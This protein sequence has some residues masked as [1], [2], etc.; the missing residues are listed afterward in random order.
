M[1]PWRNFT[2]GKWQD[3]IDVRDFIQKN[4]TPYEGD[5]SCLLYTSHDPKECG[6]V[7]FQ[8][9][10]RDRQHYGNRHWR[11][12]RLRREYLLFWSQRALYC[13]R[14][15]LWDHIEFDS[16]YRRK[17]LGKRPIVSV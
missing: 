1:D 7:Q 6:Y 4:Y 9:Y 12:V 13:R 16:E 3:G 8:E 14:R 5:E 15:Y 17:E 11:T 2:A 10:S